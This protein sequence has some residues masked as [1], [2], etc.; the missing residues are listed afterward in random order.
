MAELMHYAWVS[1]AVSQ[2]ASLFL[3]VAGSYGHSHV[4]YTCVVLSLLGVAL[5]TLLIGNCPVSTVRVSVR[6]SGCVFS[7]PPQIP[8]QG[9][10]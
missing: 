1:Q 6:E 5:S 7:F 3:N 10:D 4:L 9:R 8:E 2:R